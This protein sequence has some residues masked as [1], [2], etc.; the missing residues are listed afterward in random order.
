V[1]AAI[2]ALDGAAMYDAGTGRSGRSGGVSSSADPLL[3]GGLLNG[4][5]SVEISDLYPEFKFGFGE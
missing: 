1:L 3:L 4:E 2:L 5:A